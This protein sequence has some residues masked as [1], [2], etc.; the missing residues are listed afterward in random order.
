MGIHWLIEAD[1]MAGREE[2]AENHTIVKKNGYKFRVSSDYNLWTVKRLASLDGSFDIPFVQQID[3]ANAPLGPINDGSRLGLFISRELTE[4][5]GGQI[6]VHSAEGVGSTFFLSIRAKHSMCAKPAMPTLQINGQPHDGY[7][8]RQF[9]ARVS[10]IETLTE[11]STH[12][13]PMRKM[14][15][16]AVDKSDVQDIASTPMSIGPLCERSTLHVLVVEDNVVNQ[17]VLAQQLSREGCVVHVANH[18]EEALSFLYRS[19]FAVDSTGTCQYDPDHS[20]EVQFCAPFAIPLSVI[21]MD[22]KMPVMD[23]LTCV[24]RIRE[25]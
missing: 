18:G 3:C 8:A 5:Q 22:V 4:L 16:T 12:L 7:F 21:L 23:G 24:A 17:K 15:T 14:E 1:N 9:Q 19:S 20:R 11:K 2:G 10:S 6:G 25:L 13:S